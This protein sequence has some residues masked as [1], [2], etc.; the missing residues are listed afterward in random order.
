MFGLM[1]AA[2]IMLF[3]SVVFIVCIEIFAPQYFDFNNMKKCRTKNNIRSLCSNTD[4]KKG[5]SLGLMYS[6]TDVNKF[7]QSEHGK[8]ISQSSKN[9]NVDLQ[10]LEYNGRIDVYGYTNTDVKAGEEL[11]VDYTSSKSPKPNPQV[12]KA[13]DFI[14][15]YF[16][17]K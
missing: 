15:K 2:I 12:E 4:L 5:S 6:I 17:K 13:D 9:P 11:T 14:L 7:N 1:K 8:L 3:F 16:L 10:K